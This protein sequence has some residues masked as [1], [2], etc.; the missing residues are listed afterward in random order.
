MKWSL[1]AYL[2]LV[3]IFT[4]FFAGLAYKG[5][6]NV[7][8]VVRA[9]S[10]YLAILSVTL[11]GFPLLAVPLML[12]IISIAKENVGEKPTKELYRDFNMACLLISL[13]SLIEIILLL[14]GILS[15]ESPAWFSLLISSLALGNFAAFTGLFA[16]VVILLQKIVVELE[17]VF[18]R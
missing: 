3:T 8:E 16:L 1:R 17:G 7:I 14:L 10:G 9:V 18:T 12:H 13:G 6:V 15:E 2:L 5:A 11:I 4:V